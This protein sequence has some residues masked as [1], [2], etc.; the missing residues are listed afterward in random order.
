MP[1]FADLE[2]WRTILIVFAAVGQTLFVSFYLTLP[3]WRT[4]LGRALFVKA[5]S[6]VL[7]LDIAVV[8]RTIDWTHEDLTFVILYGLMGLGIWT[9]LVAFVKQGRG[10]HQPLDDSDDRKEPNYDHQTS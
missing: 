7:L 6:L 8:G 2:L 1:D 3:W 4:F 5:T 9:Q 10:R